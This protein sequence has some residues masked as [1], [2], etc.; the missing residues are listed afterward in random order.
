MYIY[1]LRPQAVKWR[2]QRHHFC[3]ASCSYIT[4]SLNNLPTAL[5]EFL[6]YLNF[7]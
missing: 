6:K 4:I 7:T 1:I 3:D 5:K 2:L